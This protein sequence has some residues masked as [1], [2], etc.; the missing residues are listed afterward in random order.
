MKTICKSRNDMLRFVDMVTLK[1]GMTF[2][3]PIQV[4]AEEKKSTR[5][6]EQNS[7]LFGVCYKTLL[8]EGGLREKG[9]DADDVHEFYCGE[10]F[11]WK[12]LKGLGRPKVKPVRTTTTDIYGKRSV[13][14]K[15]EF[16]D[17]IA[18]IQQKAAELGV[19]IEDPEEQ[20]KVC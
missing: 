8:D 9:F 15:M 11:G 16:S 10:C 2:D 6:L 19:I 5:S 13:L 17:F 1:L 4:S 12:T 14:N 7:Y 18:F 3:K 20:H